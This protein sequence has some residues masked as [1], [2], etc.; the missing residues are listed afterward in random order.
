[1]LQTTWKVMRINDKKFI[2]EASAKAQKSVD[3]ILNKGS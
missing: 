2:I 3:Y 1:M